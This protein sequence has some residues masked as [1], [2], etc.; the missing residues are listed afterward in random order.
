MTIKQTHNVAQNKIPAY[1]S[2][3][4]DAKVDGMQEKIL[5]GRIHKNTFLH[6][7]GRLVTI[8]RL[9]GRLDC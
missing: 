2:A 9:I 5:I 7:V 3:M 1:C 6:V 8:T 4:L